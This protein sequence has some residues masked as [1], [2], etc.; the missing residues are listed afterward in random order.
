MC[1]DALPELRSLVDL[2]V[3]CPEYARPP[4]VMSVHRCLPGSSLKGRLC[5][6][7]FDPRE[8]PGGKLCHGSQFP[9]ALLLPGAEGARR[10]QVR[11]WCSTPANPSTLVETA[12]SDTPDRASHQ[13]ARSCSSPA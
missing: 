11:C 8:S 3:G 12:G 1:P 10:G 4:G 6:S 7:R 2:G 5:L 9:Q 13:A